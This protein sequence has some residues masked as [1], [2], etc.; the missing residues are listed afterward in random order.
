[1]PQNYLKT[2]SKLLD[3][4][5]PSPLLEVWGKK[6]C[7][8]TF[9]L[10]KTPVFKPPD[11]FRKLPFLLYLLAWSHVLEAEEDMTYLKKKNLHRP[12]IG[13]V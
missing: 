2:A 10:V 3:L 11:F 4:L 12:F 9:G 13:V 5:W 7:L 6:K 1:M 8:E